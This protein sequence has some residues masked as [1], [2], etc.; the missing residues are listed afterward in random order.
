MGK[1]EILSI[2]N[3]YPISDR[4]RLVEAILKKIREEEEMARGKEP[5]EEIEYSG[6]SI[7][8]FAGILNEESA[9]TMEEAIEDSRK[10]DLDE[11]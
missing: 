4:I 1:S 3:G 5:A 10:I 11:W 9:K 8:M 2:V 7:L 6:E